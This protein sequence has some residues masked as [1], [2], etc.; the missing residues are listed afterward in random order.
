MNDG[1]WIALIIGAVVAAVVFVLR[2][3]IQKFR[4]RAD[5]KGVDAEVGTHEKTMQEISDIEQNGKNHSIATARGDTHIR[6]VKQSGES[7]KINVK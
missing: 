3:N 4:L 2:G 7:C 6:N 5:K 1:I